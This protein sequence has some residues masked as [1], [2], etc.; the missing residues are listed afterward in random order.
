MQQSPLALILLAVVAA[1]LAGAI[2]W[3]ARNRQA[4]QERAILEGALAAERSRADAVAGDAA[5]LPDALAR[6]TRSENAL[7][8]AEQS[9]R[10][11]AIREGCLSSANEEIGKHRDQLQADVGNG[12]AARAELQRQFNE[13]REQLATANATARQAN[14]ESARLAEDLAQARLD[15]DASRRECATEILARQE[16]TAQRDAVLASHQVTKLFVEDAEGKLRTAFV[17]AA[18]KVFD[19]KAVVLDRKIE[20]SGVESRKGLESVLRPFSDQVG[21]LRSRMEQLSSEDAVAR[22]TLVGSIGELK[23]LNQNMA[24]AAEGL[25][26]AL[27]GNA[28]ARGDWGELILQSVLEASGLVEGKNF[29]RQVQATDGDTGQ[30]R[31]PDIVIMLPDGREVVVDSK[32]NLVDWAEASRCEDAETYRECLTRHAAAMKT[33]M[34]SLSEIDYPR[35]LGTHCLEITVMFVPIE[36][37][38]SGALAANPDLQVEAFAKRVVFASPNTLV[39]MLAVVERLWA[40]DKLQKQINVIGTEAGKV[41][42]AVIAFA[43]EFNDIEF[44]IGQSAEAFRVAKNRLTESPQS[45]IART[46]RLV[47]AGAKG[48]KAIPEEL[49]PVDGVELL[50][51]RVDGDAEPL[52]A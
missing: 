2:A 48:K 19:D 1:L 44:R 27:T 29:R 28:K 46:R 25:T 23:T 43:E 3:W 30:R 24:D 12:E 35:I 33:H 8:A 9:L 22:A 16:A 14:L 4:R 21:Q 32:V 41:V 11:A 6:V 5:R 51:F 52:D 31:A 20:A 34:K 15:L 49:T 50:A 18:S 36:G 42:D 10:D 38:L 37:A 47:A 45:V 40:R 39:V 26:K 7:S 17:E 13:T